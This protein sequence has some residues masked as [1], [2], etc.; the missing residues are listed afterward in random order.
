MCEADLDDGNTL[1]KKV[2]NAQIAQFNFILGRTF[3]LTLKVVTSIKHKFKAV[4]TMIFIR[5]TLD[6]KVEKRLS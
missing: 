4:L 1:N 2:R 5:E 3:T 6:L